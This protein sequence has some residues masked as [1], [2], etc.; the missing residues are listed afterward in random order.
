MVIGEVA[1]A[2]KTQIEIVFEPFIESIDNLLVVK[3]ENQMVEVD[4][5]I[6][7]L[8]KSFSRLAFCFLRAR[9]NENHFIK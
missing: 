2:E 5:H 8:T 9:C 6:F 1:A 4:C 7:E 3:E